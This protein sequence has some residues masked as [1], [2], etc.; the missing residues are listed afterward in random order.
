MDEQLVWSSDVDSAPAMAWSEGDGDVASLWKLATSSGYAGVSWYELKDQPTLA[1]LFSAAIAQE[2]RE[3]CA[4]GSPL[5]LHAAAMQAT[6]LI[7]SNGLSFPVYGAPIPLPNSD[8]L[9]RAA[10]DFLRKRESSSRFRQSIDDMGVHVQLRSS[11]MDPR[12]LPEPV[13]SE[14]IGYLKA[15]GQWH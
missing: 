7:K 5:S 10:L 2:I 6:A 12:Y 3:A 15:H 1:R 13:R 11:S 4:A 9:S 14:V 8:W